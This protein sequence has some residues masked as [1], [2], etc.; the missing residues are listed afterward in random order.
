MMKTSNII[1]LSFGVCTVFSPFLKA[2]EHYPEGEKREIIYGPIEEKVPKAE[3]K[4]PQEFFNNLKNKSKK[5][6]EG[7][8]T[9]N[10]VHIRSSDPFEFERFYRSVPEEIK[11]KAKFKIKLDAHGFGD[12]KKFIKKHG[13]KDQKGL[14]KLPYP[15][16]DVLIKNGWLKEGREF[17]IWAPTPVGSDF[18]D[19]FF[20]GD[21]AFNHVFLT[22][23]YALITG[24]LKEAGYDVRRGK[25]LWQID[26]GS[27]WVIFH[28]QDFALRAFQKIKP[29]AP[30]GFRIQK[31]DL[32]LER[33]LIEEGAS[34]THHKDIMEV[35]GLRRDLMRMVLDIRQAGASPEV[36]FQ[37]E[38]MTKEH[39]L[40]VFQEYIN[41]RKLNEQ[42]VLEGNAGI[43]S[44]TFLEAN[45]ISEEK[46]P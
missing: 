11:K 41:Q 2:S 4:T 18:S 23:E 13:M 16:F 14:W 31:R 8:R 24:P 25:E 37:Q 6:T 20:L 36:Y 45:A 40:E 28:D 30:V 10:G 15:S 5:W 42:P 33:K 35:S 26:S 7:F 27:K 44:N 38:S 12:G 39:L 43:S 29:Q 3:S 19:K 32:E 17:S 21:K 46:N 22:D 1:L 34:V 9:E